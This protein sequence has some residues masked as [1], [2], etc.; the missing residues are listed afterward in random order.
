MAAV[1]CLATSP[2]AFLNL[3]FGWGH[4]A[5]MGRM[6]ADGGGH[7]DTQTGSAWSI[8]IPNNS[9]SDSS[10]VWG[11]SGVLKFIRR[12]NLNCLMILDF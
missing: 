6:D 1:A 5:Y 8:T 10:V 12:V 9:I 2:E 4:S 11:I 7:L 3:L